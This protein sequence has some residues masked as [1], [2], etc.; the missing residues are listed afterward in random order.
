MSKMESAHKKTI[1][2]VIERIHDLWL[3]KEYDEIGD[4][5]SEDVVTA[6]PGYEKRIHGRAAYVQSYREYDQSASTREF[7]PGAPEIDVIGDTAVAV[8]P[9]FV[10]YELDGQEYQEEGRDILVFSRA[11]GEWKVA[12]RTMQIDSAK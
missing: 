9:F 4:L 2:Q 3:K 11:T 8:C 10:V 1:R 6:P 12:W 5:L 7:S